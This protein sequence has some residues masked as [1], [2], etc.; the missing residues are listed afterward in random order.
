LIKALTRVD[1]AAVISD[2]IP[3]LTFLTKLQGYHKIFK[4]IRKDAVRIG[5]KML[6]VE[7]HRALAQERA[8]TNN[9]ADYVPDFVDMLSE[10][11][12]DDGKPLSDEHLLVLKI[13]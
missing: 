8:S 1:F 4:D 13:L 9:Q 12:L 3:N 5:G 6:E 11:P 10:E 2:F 7:K